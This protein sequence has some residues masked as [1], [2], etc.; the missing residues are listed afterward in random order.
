M[1]E[2]RQNLKASASARAAADLLSAAKE[3]DA[4]DLKLM[5]GTVAARSNKNMVN[6]VTEMVK[7]GT[8]A[9]WDNVNGVWIDAKAE[10]IA[11][12]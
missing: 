4:K 2:L 9:R 5:K 6:R 10:A 3:T 12:L 8:S 1:R 7:F 11:F